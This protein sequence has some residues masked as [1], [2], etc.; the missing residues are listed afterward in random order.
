MPALLQKDTTHHLRDGEVVIA[1][2]P[3]TK[4]WQYRIKRPKGDWEI[5]S[6]K[7]ADLELA[8]EVATDRYDEIR[9]LHKHELPLDKSKKFNDVASLYLKQLTDDIEAGTGKPVFV[10]YASV[11]NTWLLPFFEGVALLEVDEDKITP[12]L[13]LSLLV[14]NMNSNL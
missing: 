5:R 10:S 6:T 2:R 13:S 4:K 8:K 3:N 11:I 1:K 9:Y 14:E 7:T 12:V